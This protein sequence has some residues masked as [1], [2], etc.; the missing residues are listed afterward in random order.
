M[1]NIT[2][3][4]TSRR[5]LRSGWAM[6]LMILALSQGPELPVRACTPPPAPSTPTPL[7]FPTVTTTQIV[8]SWTNVV[9]ESG[10][11]IDRST[12]GTNW[13]LSI[14]SLGADVT[15]FSD[16]GRTAGSRY[17]YRVYAYNTGGNS[18]YAAGNKYT[19]CVAPGAPSVASVS[20]SA[21]TPSWS[22]VSG[23]ASYKVYRSTTSG[24]TYSQQGG[25]ISTTSYADT[26][27][28]SASSQYFYKVV[29]VNGEGVDSDYSA[30]GSGYTRC[31]APA[32]PT[33]E[34]VSA[35]ALR[36]A[37]S[38]VSGAT[39][40]KVYRSTS[41]GGTYTQQ[42]GTTTNLYYDDTTGMAP[43][44]QY[45]YEIVAV[46]AG[47]D[48]A[49][50]SPG[51]NWT[52]PAALAN[53][54]AT[55]TSS[56]QINLAWTN[57]TSATGFKIRRSPNGTDTW[58]TRTSSLAAGSTAY[59]DLGLAPLTTYYYQV[60]PFNSGGNAANSNTPYATTLLDAP[61]NLRVVSVATN[62]LVSYWDDVTSETGYILDRSLN[63][64]AHWGQITSSI[65]ANVTSYSNF[66]GL[67][68]GIHV[69]YRLRAK[70][71]T[72]GLKVSAYSNVADNWTRP[73]ALTALTAT[74]VSG[75]QV[76]LNWESVTGESG[77]KIER[78]LTGAA[79]S[80]TTV[81]TLNQAD[82]TSHT[83]SGLSPQT[84]YYF[85]VHS[86]NDGG[87][88][89]HSNTV[90][91]LTLP[92][93]P[94][95][96]GAEAASC[97][98]LNLSWNSVS[99]VTGYKL[100]RSPDNT[101][102]SWTQITTTT[103]SVTTFSDTGLTTG[104]RYYY[105]VRS[106][107]GAAN[108]A[109]CVAASGTTLPAPPVITSVTGV[110]STSPQLT[111]T[112]TG[113]AN[114][115]GYKLYRAGSLGGS[116]AQLLNP[117]TGQP[118]VVTG[119]SC[120]DAWNMSLGTPYYY[121]MVAIN[122]GGE[123][124]QSAPLGNWT[125][126]AAPA[127]PT[128]SDPTGSS[129]RA[130]WSAVTGATSYRVK[131]STNVGGPFSD[132]GTTEA[133]TH[134]ASG[135]APDTQY[136]I[137]IYAINSGGE[138]MNSMPGLGTT[139]TAAPVISSVE[140]LT[141]SSLKVN[142]G[143]V[144]GATSYKVYR[145][146]DSLGLFTQQGGSL[147]GTS[148]TDSGLAAGTHYFYKVTAL[149]ANGE[150]APSAVAS[151]W[152]PPRVP[153]ITSVDTLSSCSLMVNWGD[154]GGT[155][156]LVSRS[157]SEEGTYAAC[158]DPVTTTTLTDTG[159]TSNTVYWYKVA[160]VNESG[161]SEPSAAAQGRTLTA[162]PV[163]MAVDSISSSSLKAS[164]TAVSG[165]TAYRVEHSTDSAT[166]TMLSDV[167]TTTTFSDSGLTSNTQYWYRA[168]AVNAAGNSSPSNA[169]SAWTRPASP[170]IS[171][172]EALTTVSLKVQW[173]AVD[174]VASYRL[175]R[176]YYR[177]GGYNL[178]ADNVTTLS[179]TDSS[180]LVSG[181]RYWYKVSAVGTGGESDLS[182]P[183]AGWTRSIAPTIAS[184]DPLSSS[185]LKVSW[186]GLVGA[187]GY[188]LLRSDDGGTN[189]TQQGGVL[190]ATSFSDSG[191]A[192][193]T[194][195]WYKIVAVSGGGAD[196]EASAAHSGRTL[197]G[198][199]SV[200]T[201]DSLSSATLRISW[202]AVAGATGYKLLRLAGP[203]T[204]E[205]QGGTIGA[206]TYD[207]TPLTAGL[208]CWYK[209][210]AVGAGGDSPPSMLRSNWTRPGTPQTLTVA[211][212]SSDTLQVSWGAVA[213]AN[214]YKLYHADTENG[215]YTQRGDLLT[216]T[217]Y[218]DSDLTT[219]TQ[220][221][222]KVSALNAGGEGGLSLAA[223]GQTATSAPQILAAESCS[224]SAIRLVWGT[225][226]SATG[227][228][229]RRSDT[230]AEGSY[231]QQGGVLTGFN[232]EDASLSAG[233]RYWYKLV[234]VVG[235]NDSDPSPVASQWTRPAAPGAPAVSSLSS[236]VLGLSWTAVSSA[237]RY[238][239]Y[240]S[241][242]EGGS[243]EQAGQTD[244]TTYE[245]NTLTTGGLQYY[246][247]LSAV[248]DG[249]ASALSPAGSGTARPEV[250][251][252]SGVDSLSSTSLRVNWKLSPT[253]T[254]YKVYRAPD[255]GSTY[256]LKTTAGAID[257]SWT[258][259]S[260]LAPATRYWYKLAA[261]SEEGETS[262]SLAAGG[263]TL[264]ASPVIASVQTSVTTCLQIR[265]SA[266]SGASQGYKILRASDPAGTY[267][268][269]GTAQALSFLDEHCTEA[270]H[271]WYRVATVGEGGDSSPSLPKDGW[272]APNA[273]TEVVAVAD[274]STTPA[275]R[276]KVSWLDNSQNEG[277]FIV[278]LSLTGAEDSWTT[279]SAPSSA[280]SGRIV[281]Y[282]DPTE[283]TEGTRVY[284]RV[285]A[286]LT[287]TAP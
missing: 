214:G 210:K 230:G 151:R 7:T 167:V 268:L 18:G 125:V 161:Q 217:S 141:S 270:T 136:Y 56:T 12:D 193:D 43:S 98:Q 285:R 45:F 147:T 126:P 173:G 76:Q 240:R 196:S 178:L 50:S 182:T 101:P 22:A 233:T 236:R 279:S 194:I 224:D 131:V 235:G 21:L 90:N 122:A 81:T 216:A 128:V 41:S 54:T 192:A 258:D 132:Q 175:Y 5:I 114:N 17:W 108:S 58:T 60:I 92:A 252:L 142:W 149:G 283:H 102:N 67:S 189:Y 117:S 23:A 206:L 191:L 204:F 159:L 171:A 205:Q 107:N 20:A 64:T 34:S 89:G 71:D 170:V 87:N 223:S 244:Q 264:P 59:S 39:G 88:A 78:S 221:W 97:T 51:N 111:L 2:S 99:G 222:Y 113:A 259:G 246:Y 91:L 250:P 198:T 95:G 231:A 251:E 27:G 181:A 52:R 8:V 188:K 1:S 150:S 287:P 73:A 100:E 174:G 281:T 238:K 36:P 13:T 26:I 85:Q 25:T 168:R 277:E 267:M 243:Y 186:G 123:S 213:S 241:T 232:Y 93:T 245:D 256:T 79:D 10:Y 116:Y 40:Y 11:K 269:V 166:F 275:H 249:G 105:R 201:V 225:V 237:T 120:S 127:A 152:T 66:A 129:L 226:T 187:A 273:P 135:L 219:G 139:L 55:A 184:I 157:S 220:H 57:I 24:G 263:W 190:S 247:K 19:L 124:A 62:N 109:Y 16:T 118:L 83:E 255:A 185:S 253:A 169:L 276:M 44:T 143:T 28:L 115:T 65:G 229:L 261:T 15:T 69:Y 4:H 228:K 30:Y 119:A 158:G 32:T 140:L 49:F 207:D 148:F 162:A 77:F 180:G 112:W 138:S 179:Q 38:A 177:S 154:A 31:A 215:A 104:T 272:S 271:Y 254:G 195:Y 94:T 61:K 106:N 63:D 200:S 137:Q 48:S 266:V 208:H 257:T 14:A 164:W 130:S 155:S 211:L 165:A 3:R 176:S 212:T 75:T 265:W 35:S 209:V 121:K 286:R 202:S 134:V 80:W 248:N 84:H 46:N 183:T 53:V 160:A 146:T 70:N 96:L 86:S 274:D 103:L 260:G 29:A 9:N 163:L 282:H 280:G 110:T 199:P 82:V 203:G 37:W 262:C 242:S 145:T 278:E 197:T 42:G 153:V 156:Y 227:Y 68:A 6:M 47:G 72:N 284:Y 33:V 144:A 234:A 74:A 218:R 239:I 133:L 172:V